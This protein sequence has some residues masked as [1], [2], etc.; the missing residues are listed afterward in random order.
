[1]RWLFLIPI[2]G[3]SLVD[4]QDAEPGP[5]NTTNYGY[6]T[7]SADAMAALEQ[8]NCYRNL[9]GLSRG[10]LHPL[11]D[12][13]AQSHADYMDGLGMLTHGETEGEPGFTGE[14]AEDRIYA[15]GYP[16]ES[17]QKWSEVVAWGHT[18]Q[19]AIEAWMG[20]VYHRIPFTMSSWTHIGFGQAADYS[21]MSF[22]SPWPDGTR[23]A[24]VFPVDGQTDVPTSFDSDSEIPDPAPDHGIVG[25]P[26]T[27]TVSAEETY[28]SDSNNPYDLR[29]EDAVMWGPDGE[30][31]ETLTMDPTM[32]GYLFAMAAIVPLSPLL[33][34]S[35]YE[36]EI[37]VSYAD[38]S[39]T[40]VTTFETAGP[41]E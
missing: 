7:P 30:E 18:P 14:N 28:G 4:K 19:E 24:V 29:L 22:V 34:D 39:Q 33:P 37:S 38:Q 12:A 27:V 1:M 15:A 26:I 20:T 35:T 9:M 2:C 31:V 23:Q 5:C 13:A 41:D 40:L 36:V 16:F 25:Y 8:T 17:G 11:L 32:D 3:C 21:S 6:G 10:R